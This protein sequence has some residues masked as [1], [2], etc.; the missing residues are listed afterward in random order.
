MPVQF[1]SVSLVWY[2]NDGIYPVR[3]WDVEVNRTETQLIC[4]LE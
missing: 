4:T 3:S 2:L 1:M